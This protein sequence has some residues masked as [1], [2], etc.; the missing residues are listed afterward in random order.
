MTTPDDRIRPDDRITA[1][2]LGA[3]APDDG[4]APLGELLPLVYAELHRM[5]ER[6][7]RHERGA[8]TL[9]P[10]ELV[11]EAYLRLA[12]ASGVTARGRAYFFAAAAQAMRRIVVEYARS[13]GRLK[14]G[15]GQAA[16]TLEDVES[17]ADGGD[18]DLL[19]IDD[20]LDR[21][22]TVAERPARVVECRFFGGLTVDETAL[23]LGITPRTVNRD[24]VFARA[25]LVDQLGH[26]E[27][28]EPV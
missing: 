23:A 19:D 2:L 4:A 15:G 6:R 14:R 1:L 11:H 24:W 12:G 17:V 27:A 13:R 21:L 22:A 20:A 9:S 8:V 5:A 18:A 10:T 7:L 25:W 3:G 16:V 26:P 28:A